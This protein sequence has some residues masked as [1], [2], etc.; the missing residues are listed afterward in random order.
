LRG[1]AMKLGS[2]PRPAYGVRIPE[3][4]AP[5]IVDAARRLNMYVTLMLSFNRETAPRK[6]IESA[7]ERYYYFGHTGTPIEDFIRMS[8]EASKGLEIVEVEADHVSIM[9]SV[10]RAIMRISGVN[11]GYIPLTDQE[12]TE[13]LNYIEEE[14]REALSAGGVDSVT[15]DTCELIDLSV[16]ALSDK[17]VVDLFES[18]FGRDQVDDLKKRYL[19]KVFRFVSKDSYVELKFRYADIARLALKFWKS[20]E[21]AYR[22]ASR[23]KELFGND[24]GIEIALDETP[25]ETAPKELF[26]YINEL[27]QRGIRFE[28]IAPNVGFKK[29]EDYRGDLRELYNKIR[30]LHTIASNNGVYLSIHSGSGSHPYS[31]KGAGVW[32]TVGM[33]TDGLVKYKM[34]GVLIQLLLEVM[35]KFPSGSAVRRVYEEIY[36]AVV[37]RLKKDL[38]AGKGLASDALRKLLEDYEER[39]SRYDVRADVFRYYFFVFQSVRD[40][41]GFRYLR[42]RVV[43]LFEEDRDLRE[44][45]RREAMNLVERQAEAL[46]YIDSVI[47]YRRVIS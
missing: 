30:I 33:A 47:R 6:Y 11:I 19:D 20:I 40:S 3:V 24:I 44:R 9:G 17:D 2:L 13:S 10:E 7:D 43:E 23:A 41:K 35:S 18:K 27:F 39:G 5:I 31:D 26:F 25:A 21:Y 38:A 36:D 12:L 37:D 8:R 34:S 14:F 46:G 15:I 29:R 32:K 22:L 4:V 28:F 16:D 1:T 42:S 45:Y